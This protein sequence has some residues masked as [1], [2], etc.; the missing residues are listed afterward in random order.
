[1]SFVETIAISQLSN[2]PSFVLSEAFVICRDTCHLIREVRIF[3]RCPCYPVGKPWYLNLQP[4]ILAAD[5]V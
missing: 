1:V 2:S 5:G 4:R 3:A